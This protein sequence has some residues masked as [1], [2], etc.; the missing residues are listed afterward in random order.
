MHTISN[1]TVATDSDSES[2]KLAIHERESNT[3]DSTCRLLQDTNDATGSM[4]GIDLAGKCPDVC[5][6][7][8][9][10]QEVIGPML[11]WSNNL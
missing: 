2:S 11:P 4:S 6:E 8:A 3:L 7:P 5:L 1:Y 10:A 9:A